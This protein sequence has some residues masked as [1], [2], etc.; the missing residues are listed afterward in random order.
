MFQ[1]CIGEFYFNDQL[2]EI[3]EPT[4]APNSAD[5]VADVVA[6]FNVRDGCELILFCGQPGAPSCGTPFICKNFWKGPFC[7]CPDRVSPHLNDDG[8]VMNCGEQVAML[9][10]G[11][12]SGAVAAILISLLALISKLFIVV[13]FIFFCFAVFILCLFFLFI[14]FCK[15][16]EEFKF[17]N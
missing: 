6:H 9:R 2:V 14:C 7:T 4:R 8:T 15:F 10:L 1:G 16:C 13:I 12:T 3:I 11:I 5:L 17:V